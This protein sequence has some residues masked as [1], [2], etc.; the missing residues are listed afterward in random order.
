MQPT[1]IIG[2]R[3]TLAIRDAGGTVRETGLGF[4]VIAEALDYAEPR[5]VS[6]TEAIITDHEGNRPTLAV[7]TVRS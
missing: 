4:D 6:G 5:L 2:G 3:Y 1:Q 7:R